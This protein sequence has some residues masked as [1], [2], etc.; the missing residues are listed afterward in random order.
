MRA[1][2]TGQVCA[3]C[4]MTSPKAACRSRNADNRIVHGAL[5]ASCPVSS[6]LP[7]VM[8]ANARG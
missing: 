1:P 3:H 2:M 7:F 5:V 8:S 4:E 6:R